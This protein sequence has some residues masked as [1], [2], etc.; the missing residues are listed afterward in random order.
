MPLTI[1][2]IRCRVVWAFEVMIDS[3]SPTRAFIK[4]DFPTL[5]FPI[6]LTKPD[7]CI[8]LGHTLITNVQQIWHANYMPHNSL[9]IIN[10]FH[11]NSF[12]FYI[13]DIHLSCFSSLSYNCANFTFLL[14][15]YCKKVKRYHHVPKSIHQYHF[16]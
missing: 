10:K 2:I 14:Y 7:L 1:P 9:Y 16:P 13:P 3:L 6:I 11:R 4:V 12:Q 15:D 8:I 5:G